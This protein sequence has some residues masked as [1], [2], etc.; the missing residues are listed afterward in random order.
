MSGHDDDY[1]DNT[2]PS[3]REKPASY[4]PFDHQD[5]RPR[6]DQPA[7]NLTYSQ[8]ATTIAGTS[9]ADT[10][11][12]YKSSMQDTGD[13]RVSRVSMYTYT[14]GDAEQF[15]KRI[16]E[17]FFNVL[18]D[19]YCLPTDDDEWTRLNKQHVAV[20]L[21]LSGLYPD[22]DLV[23]AVLA[24][25][26]GEPKRILDLGC[27][28][29]VW[30]ETFTRTAMPKVASYSV[31]SFY[32]ALAMAERFPHCEV[33]GMDLSPVPVDPEN[34][35]SNC[36]F[37]VDDI[38]LGLSHFHDKFDLVHSRLIAA[39]LK[40]FAK[41]KVEIEKCLKPGGLMLWI[42]GDYHVI[43]EDPHVY[44]PLASEINPEGCYLGRMFWEMRR[45]AVKVGRSDLFTMTDSLKVG[46][47]K[48]PMLDPETCKAG[49]IYLPIGTWP[50]GVTYSKVKLQCNN[51][52]VVDPDFNQSQKLKL[53]GTLIRQ[54]V[55][56][57]SAAIHPLLKNA[58]FTPETL[59]AWQ[60]KVKEELMEKNTPMW[61]RF[62]LAWG[63]RRSE[64]G[65]PAPPLP[66]VPATPYVRSEEEGEATMPP[67]PYLFVYDT[68]EQR[69]ESQAKLDKSKPTQAPPLPAHSSV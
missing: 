46:L 41:S 58:G 61:L 11:Q 51:N 2:N 47:W 48:D 23:H 20:V 62:F 6:V 40:D 18:N 28:T 39:G 63:R 44:I 53:I 60:E 33:V 42:D 52:F 27:G 8:A 21:G 25:G 24:P 43:S 50:K 13:D 16:G 55:L 32:R 7:L 67:Y 37:E 34:V 4:Q 68:E 10:S 22:P 26:N 5:V 69:R 35:P 57:A 17:R 66:A 29:G 38:N 3:S 9:I 59:N 31:I 36:R 49:D 54:D 45:C 30:Y 14:S 64:P 56:S 1:H 15:R 65:Q 12:D 19:A